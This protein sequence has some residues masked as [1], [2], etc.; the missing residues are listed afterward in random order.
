M[1]LGP[2]FDPIDALFKA[3]AALEEFN[4]FIQENTAAA[5]IAGLEEFRQ[6]LANENKNLG[7]HLSYYHGA[8]PSRTKFIGSFA[9]GLAG[10]LTTVPTFGFS[11]LIT[12]ASVFIALNDSRSYVDNL[13]QM[14]RIELRLRRIKVAL[15][16][17]DGLAGT[18]I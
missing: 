11:L 9:V 14:D 1:S 18:A 7:S 17:I 5:R 8:T 13:G 3:D 2:K 10:V 15:E 12:G 16:E 4:K 6:R